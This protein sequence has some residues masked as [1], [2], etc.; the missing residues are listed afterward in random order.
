MEP[1]E[2]KT[3]IEV[4]VIGAGISGV[5]TVK[6]MRDAGFKVL[7]VERTG[8][9]GGLWHYKEKAYGV[10]KFTHMS[11]PLLCLHLLMLMKSLSDFSLSNNECDLF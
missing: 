1:K 4:L 5:A 2:E 6:C 7:A 10:M 8:D 3:E 9:V 11:V